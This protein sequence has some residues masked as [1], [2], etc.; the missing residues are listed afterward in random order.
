MY[1][2]VADGRFYSADVSLEKSSGIFWGSSTFIP[3][4]QFGEEYLSIQ[5]T[6]CRKYAYVRVAEK[7]LEIDPKPDKV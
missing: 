7:E 3:G 1:L 5:K 4:A 6:I 2:G